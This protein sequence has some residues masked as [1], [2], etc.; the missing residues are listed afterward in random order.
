MRGKGKKRNRVTKAQNSPRVSNHDKKVI[1]QL[2]LNFMSRTKQDIGDWRNALILAENVENPSRFRLHQIYKDIELDDQVEACLRNL[3]ADL[4]SEGF[5]IGDN[6][7]KEKD[8]ELTELL[9]RPW[10]YDFMDSII[11]SKNV[12]YV[13]LELGDIVSKDG[14]TEIDHFEEVP[15]E[16]VIPERG[17]VVINTGDV[18]GFNINDPAFKRSLFPIGKRKDLGLFNKIAKSTIYKRNVEG[19]WAEFCE[20]FGMPVRIGKVGSR[21]QADM[22][23][24]EM[25]LKKMGSAAYAVTSMEDDI[26]LKETSRGDAYQVYE[27]FLDRQDKSIAKVLL[28]QTMT[29]QDGSSRS[30]AE[31]HERVGDKRM[32]DLKLFTDFLINY[33]LIPFL[34]D[35]G[36]KLEGKQFIWD[37]VT[38]IEK[39]D[40]AKDTFL[41]KHFEF[42]DLQYFIDKY[43]VPIKSV[44]QQSMIDPDNEDDPNGDK[45]EKELSKTDKLNNSIKLLYGQDD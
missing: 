36:Y 8:D 34:I 35:N 13:L 37:E 44:R 19:C 18:T 45:R 2:V 24:M 42:E 31:V 16:H 3:R 43:R 11:D 9:H 23:R 33:K 22:D 40:I 39:I 6:K 20:I 14:I 1:N 25:F 41:V 5:Y 12:G 7:T 10:F 17:L 32:F 4:K 30:Q 26:D 15:R 29:T 27:K 38:Q 28:G 21:N